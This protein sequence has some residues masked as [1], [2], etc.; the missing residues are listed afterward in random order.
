MNTERA[1]RV[2]F[3]WQLRDLDFRESLR[4]YTSKTT[5]SVKFSYKNLKTNLTREKREQQAKEPALHSHSGL[6]KPLSFDDR[7]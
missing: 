7:Q 6:I 2:V 4:P 1:S 5:P 3:S